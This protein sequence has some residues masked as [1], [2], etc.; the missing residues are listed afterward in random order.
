[1]FIDE[2][3]DG[4]LFVSGQIEGNSLLLLSG[5]DGV[6]AKP[7]MDT[8]YV[9]KWNKH[10]IMCWFKGDKQENVIIGKMEWKRTIR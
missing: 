1:L 7:S 10:Q 6:I 5:A 8:V 4:I 9:A 2:N 3:K